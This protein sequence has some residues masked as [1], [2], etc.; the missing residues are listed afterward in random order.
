V[1]R[2]TSIFLGIVTSIG[3]F[4]EAGSLSTSA[5]AG[6]NFRF[7][8]L[9]S[10]VIATVCLAVLVEMSGR[11]AAVGKRSLVGAVR[12][13]FGITFQSVPLA[14]EIVLDLLVLAAELGGMAISVQLLTGWSYRWVAIPAALAVWLLLWFGTFGSIENGVAILGLLTLC[15]VV[16]AVKMHPPLHELARGLVPQLPSGNRANYAFLAV[17]IL[18][19]TISPYML[20][21]YSSGALEEKWDEKELTS[22]KL[23]AGFGMGFGSLV[24]IG[25]LITA[26][27]VLA[28]RGIKVDD[29]DQASLMLLPPFGRWGLRLFAA[30][31]FIGC[32]GAALEVA[33]NLAYAVSQAFGWE[34]GEDHRPCDDA[35][36][37]MV[38][39]A[40]L[41]IAPL[42]MVAGIPPM[43][44][45]LFAMA[46]TT[47]ILPLVVFPFL[48]LMNDPRY[49][50]KHPNHRLGNVV[51]VGIL[52]M[53][54][55]IAVVA[56]PLEIMG[57]S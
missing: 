18:G 49:V 43:K 52:V 53:A 22:N 25:V 29:F 13:R 16:A 17:S 50:K 11:L 3:G 35:R 5:Q 1:K 30:S 10:V 24:T 56:I 32:F 34:W 44:L 54:C 37:S 48:V 33:L 14:G 36:F 45:T 6:A 2:F 38:Y 47:L 57:G 26:A 23:V 51:V 15:F 40:A 20:N 55:L 27:M 9:W 12:E 46:I 28:P 21:F 8:L 19:A 42:L 7:S 31:L 41:L 39:T 4:I